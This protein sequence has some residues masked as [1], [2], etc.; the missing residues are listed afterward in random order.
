MHDIIC[1]RFNSAVLL[2]VI[3]M[4]LIKRISAI[5]I[6][7]LMGAGSIAIALIQGSCRWGRAI[8]NPMQLSGVTE[9][10]ELIGIPALHV[11]VRC[12]FCKEADQRVGIQEP[13][14]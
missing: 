9:L 14:S 12:Y 4:T 1:V 11:L 5:P 3:V 2:V 10:Q 7:V 13:G 6:I 8:V